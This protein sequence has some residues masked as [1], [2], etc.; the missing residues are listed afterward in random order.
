MRR[1]KVARKKSGHVVRTYPCPRPFPKPKSWL[2]PWFQ[3]QSLE[4]SRVF[5]RVH[6]GDGLWHES[7]SEVL[8]MSTIRGKWLR[9]EKSYCQLVIEKLSWVRPLHDVCFVYHGMDVDMK[10]FSDL[11]AFLILMFLISLSIWEYNLYKPQ[12]INYRSFTI[13]LSFHC[14]YKSNFVLT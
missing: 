3:G 8:S 9:R 14:D 10:I 13:K 12:G 4:K 5:V 11:K 1:A 7:V 2:C 6:F